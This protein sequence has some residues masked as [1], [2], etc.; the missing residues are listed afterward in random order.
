MQVN[1]NVRANIDALISTLKDVSG[2]DLATANVKDVSVTSNDNGLTITFKTVVDGV[3]RPIVLAMTPELDAPDGATDQV[4]ME[5]LI[6]KLDAID[7]TGMTKGEAIEFVQELIDRLAEKIQASGG[8]KTTQLP[9]T[10]GTSGSATLFNLLEILT[11]LV[12]VGQ[13]IKNSAKAIKASDNEMQA[14][15]YERQAELTMAMAEAAK[16]Q[17]S[18]YLTISV[19]MMA[20]SAAVSVGA[21]IYGATK[22]AL[23]ETKAAGNESNMAHTVQNMEVNAGNVHNITTKSGLA[24]VQ[25]LPEGRLNDIK[26]T[27]ENNPDINNAKSACITAQDDIRTA[28][29]DVSIASQR[30][31]EAETAHQAALESYNSAPEGE[32]KQLAQ[33]VLD[34]KT[35]KLNEARTNLDAAKGRLEAANGRL[36]AGKVK[37]QDA[38]TNVMDK[39]KSSYTGAAKAD[40]NVKLAELTV[41]NELGF[42]MLKGETIPGDNNQTFLN[43]VSFGKMV[44]ASSASY[45]KAMGSES[46]WKMQATAQVGQFLGQLSTAL[47]QH[48]QTEV[49]YQAQSE[50]AKAQRMQAEATRMQNQYDEDKDLES[51]GQNIID[52]ANQTIS[53][54]YEGEHETTRNIF[55]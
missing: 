29:N 27:F 55:S 50:S 20:C 8:L 53:K 40:Q 14:Q 51:S 46:H 19:V 10:S 11:L 12:E 28:S 52:T 2:E 47:H 26:A 41:A 18:K 43:D 30:L 1:T 42:K 13:E 32:Q 17:S 39:F 44:T 5:E 22:A 24:A 15:A 21:G 35:Q 16:E 33:Q 25:Q 37:F 49:N 23:P 31:T 36:E 54:V 6:S 34:Q 48:W 9:S 45:R 7:V 4:A 3:E 38:V